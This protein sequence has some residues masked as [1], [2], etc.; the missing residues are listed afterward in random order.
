MFMFLVIL[1]SVTTHIYIIVKSH[2]SLCNL[3]YFMHTI[4][5]Y[6]MGTQ[7]AYMYNME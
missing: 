4:D 6:D 3:E 5:K 1:I 2:L 7:G